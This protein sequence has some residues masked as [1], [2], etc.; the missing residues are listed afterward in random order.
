MNSS[1]F[2]FMGILFII[3]EMLKKLFNFVAK[4][5]TWM[6]T[7]SDMSTAEIALLEIQRAYVRCP[8]YYGGVTGRSGR[9]T[10]KNM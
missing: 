1:K 6:S 2:Y 5:N 10:S 8:S 9:E 4:R 3:T 7:G